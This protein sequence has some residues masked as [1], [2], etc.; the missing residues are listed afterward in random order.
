MAM[1]LRLVDGLW[2][3]CTNLLDRGQVSQASHLLKRLLQLELPQ[4]MRAEASMTLAGLCRQSGDYENARKHVSAALAGDPEDPSLHHMLGYLHDEDEEGSDTRALT[5]LRKAVKLAPESS[6]CHRA[7]GEYLYHHDQQTRGMAHLRK[8]IELEPENI[9]SL[10]TLLEALVE[11]GQ[12][13][14][15]KNLLR[16]LQFR[17]GKAHPQIQRLWNTFAY[18]TAQNQQRKVTTTTATIP[19]PRPSKVKAKPRTSAQ[20]AHILRFDSAH[21]L[22]SRHLRFSPKPQK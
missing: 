14:E 22:Q 8:A 1:A 7:L 5:H 15:A 13:D 21:A 4:D 10:S 9:D 20:P 17:L 12:I 18:L 19:L 2:S 6:E 3:R 16:Q 11:Q